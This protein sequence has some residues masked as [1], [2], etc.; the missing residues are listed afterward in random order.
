MACLSAARSPATL[1]P[2]R[3]EQ[4][5]RAAVVLVQQR[6]EQVLRLDV[7]V[8]VADREALGVG[9]RLLEPGRELVYA[10]RCP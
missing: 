9:E 1:T 3:D 2:A 10:H 4:R 7:R 5:R 8:V 6:G